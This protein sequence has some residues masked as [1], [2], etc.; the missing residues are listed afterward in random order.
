MITNLRIGLSVIA[1]LCW[2]LSGPL[3]S[4]DQASGGSG[5]SGK[6]TG[7][8]QEQRS[9]PDTPPQAGSQGQQGMKGAGAPMEKDT[10]GGD[11]MIDDKEKTKKK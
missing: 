10:K 1:M 3:A 2:V 7:K 6:G 4:A 9:Q 8:E 5:S 11:K